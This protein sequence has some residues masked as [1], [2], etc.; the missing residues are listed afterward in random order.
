MYHEN[1]L[2]HRNI[3]Y[4][5]IIKPQFSDIYAFIQLLQLSSKVFRQVQL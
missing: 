2:E 5:H 1:T 4:Y 3:K